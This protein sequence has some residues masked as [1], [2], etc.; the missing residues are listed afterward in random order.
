MT[1]EPK[2]PPGEKPS[3]RR[4][5]AK[6]TAAGA[7]ATPAPETASASGPEAPAE[8]ASGAAPEATAQAAPE[9]RARTAPPGFSPRPKAHRAAGGAAR[10]L[11]WIVLVGGV[12]IG[13]AA[14]TWPWWSDK[15]PLVLPFL[16]ANVRNDPAL[17]VL[18][19]RLEALEQKAQALETARGSAYAQLEQERARFAGDLKDMVARL[20]QLENAVKEARGLIR[21]ADSKDQTV[22]AAQSL[23][24]LTSRLSR[25]E[26]E[27]EKEQ[28]MP[29]AA[30][31]QE[32][33]AALSA[34]QDRLQ[35]LETSRSATADT[36][37]ARAIVLAV[38][39]LRDAVRRGA[40]FDRDLEALRSVAG[41]DAEIAQA[42][43][44]LAPHA[45]KGVATLAVLRTRFQALAGTIVAAGAGDG[46]PGWMAEAAD[47]LSSLVK[48]RRVGDK[49]PAG[50]V[51]ALVQQVDG[52]LAAG[53][54]QGAVTLV[55][56]L[57]G[58]ARDAADSW[59][60]AAAARLEAEKAV[61]NLHVLAVALLSP[62][63]TGG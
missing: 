9:R 43:A 23:D 48:V 46:A 38:A 12:A 7:A 32:I 57:A 51:D 21:A 44:H 35:R 41:G 55:D 20:D 24:D 56:G 15:V 26:K 6:K 14:V 45:A 2:N 49:A 17:Q 58:K 1:S 25:L 59:R 19:G 54:L 50:S 11:A 22:A 16:D 10:L 4:A 39:Q 47:K 40:A 27:V 53:D 62:A 63:G 31:D 52:L 13:A 42:M 61:A 37:S 30:S 29:E 34:M 36:A 18:T 60:Q 5:R 8:P 28:A 33:K 3:A